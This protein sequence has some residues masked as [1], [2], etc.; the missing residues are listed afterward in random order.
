M[1][2][3]QAGGINLARSHLLRCPGRIQFDQ[4][5]LIQANAVEGEEGVGEIV[6]GG[7][8]H[9]ADALAA[10]IGRRCD[11]PVGTRDKAVVAR[12]GHSRQDMKGQAFMH[13]CH[14]G[15]VRHGCNVHFFVGQVLEATPSVDTGNDFHR[16][17]LGGKKT[18]PVG[19][20]DR[21]KIGQLGH[22]QAQRLGLGDGWRSPAREQ[23]LRG[24]Q[25]PP[26]SPPTI[27]HDI[28]T[29]LL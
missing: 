13:G 3:V 28:S 2:L 27:R 23:E 19:N 4:G 18:L 11:A 12:R 29:E 7:A 17:A 5:D 10:Q 8:S 24:Q 15:S 1:G 22:R 14:D 25:P 9:K 6:T 21:R 26:V 20:E 16:Q